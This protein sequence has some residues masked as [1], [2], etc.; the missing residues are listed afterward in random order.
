MSIRSFLGSINKRENRNFTL[1]DVKSLRDVLPE[2][3][4]KTLSG[5]SVTA[6]TSMG[7]SAVFSSVRVISEDLASVPME[8]IKSE[9]GTKTKLYNHYLYDL[10][11]NKPNHYQ[12][13]FTFYDNLAAMANLWGNAYVR[14]HRN[15][16]NQPAELEIIHPTK[17][18]Y[19]LINRRLWYK[20]KEEEKLIRSEDIIHICGPSYDGVAGVPMIQLHR[21][22]IGGGLAA[23]DYGNTLFS[24]GASLN[25]LLTSE[26]RL[27][28]PQIKEYSEKWNEK[29]SQG[30]HNAHQTAVLGQGLKYQS[31]GIPPDDAQF[32]ETKKY[33]RS[34]IAG[35]F[36]V[37]AHKINDLEKATFS[38]IEQMSIEH[39]GDSIRPWAKRFEQAFESKLITAGEKAHIS[40]KFNL[41]A[42]MRGDAK[43]RMEYYKGMQ[44]VGVY[45][46]NDIRSLE[47]ENIYPGGD[48]R[49]IPLNSI[50]VDKIDQYFDAKIEQLL[51]KKQSDGTKNK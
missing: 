50:P 1:T 11:H 25:G 44:G 14:I 51:S 21:E 22:T 49:F 2:L 30:P 27:T 10:I 20:Y 31:I 12:T 4:G 15:G 9:S 46:A 43:S 13:P 42:L 8:V 17:I 34:E 24:N 26:Q 39:V 38:N 23:K 16:K 40:L 41:N 29:Y 35:I 3:F 28:E 33:S 32:I 19:Y 7:L 47:G 48:Q 45:S 6:D 18:R 5:V 37:K 36:R